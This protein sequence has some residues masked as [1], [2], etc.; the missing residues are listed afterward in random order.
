[1]ADTTHG[2][3]APDSQSTERTV[4]RRSALAVVG[5]TAAVAVAPFGAA[6][7][8]G[9]SPELEA[10]IEAYHSAYAQWAIADERLEERTDAF[11][12]SEE[13]PPEKGEASWK[14]PCLDLD[15]RSKGIRKRW[16]VLTE[17]VEFRDDEAREHFL[18]GCARA[19]AAELQAL[20]DH[21]AQDASTGPRILAKRRAY[22]EARAAAQERRA[23]EEKAFGLSAA[24]A[25][26]EAKWNGVEAAIDALVDYQPRSFEDIRR[27]A[28]CM[29]GDA[30]ENDRA[31]LLRE[32]IGN[33][34]YLED[35]YRNI[36]SI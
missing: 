35:W 6:A 11:K 27:L 10:L 17:F 36:A 23:A 25:E 14:L 18:A 26:Y 15:E 28:S 34:A 7:S 19:E 9:P 3:P 32:T 8:P 20:P 4:T 29:I 21:V 12:P 22:E 16:A 30:R 33:P 13:V 2:A 31:F 24:R 1:M 5:T